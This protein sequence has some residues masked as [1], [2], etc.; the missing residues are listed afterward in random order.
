MDKASTNSKL[1]MRDTAI[2][3]LRQHKGNLPV[4]A[5]ELGIDVEYLRKLSRGKWENPGIN[6]IEIILRY[7]KL[8]PVDLQHGNGKGEAAA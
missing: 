6:N 4:V 2:A 8:W 3:Y 5:E 1:T 7:A